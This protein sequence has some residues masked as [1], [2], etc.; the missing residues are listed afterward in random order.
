MHIFNKAFR[1]LKKI[2]KLKK[3]TSGPWEFDGARDCA[4]PILGHPS[5]IQKT[6]LS[7]L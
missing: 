5:D 1:V 6:H 7:K 4:G 2:N 3:K